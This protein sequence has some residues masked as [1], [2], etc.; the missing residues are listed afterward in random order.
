VSRT[1][2]DGI[3]VALFAALAAAP[4]VP[5]R[6]LPMVDLPQHELV[7]DALRRHLSGT[8]GTPTQL[9]AFTYNAGFEFGVLPLAPFLGVVT[10]GHVLLA[11]ACAGLVI[12]IARLRAL[13][14]LDRSPALVASLFT[15][16]YAASWG[17]ANF[18]LGVPLVFFALGDALVLHARPS[19]RA[20]ARALVTALA[21]AITHV[22]AAMAACLGLALVAL[23]DL[24][25]DRRRA[26]LV[27]WVRAGTPLAVAGAYDV[28]AFLWARA[29]PHAPWEN[30]WAEG[31][32]A[33][34]LVRLRD[35]AWNALGTSGDAFESFVV[36]GVLVTFA[37]ALLRRADDRGHAPAPAPDLRALPLG[38][39]AA[40]LFVP[41]VFVATFYVGERFASLA[42]LALVATA[43]IPARGTAAKAACAFA[44]V[45]A[46]LRLETTIRASDRAA[47]DGLAVLAAIPPSASLLPVNRDVS[48]TGF[49][50]APLRHLFARHALRSGAPVG[51]SF[52]RFESPP[53]RRTLP[54]AL[55]DPPPGF[56]GDGRGLAHDA[57]FAHAW[58]ALFVVDREG[59]DFASDA[60]RE[61]VAPGCGAHLELIAARGRFA[62]YRWVMRRTVD[63][64]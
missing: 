7:A 34:V 19:G 27:A 63:T 40:Y 37:F 35:L 24:V 60:Y 28:G 26:N 48:L 10:A 42:L 38:F 53:V 20:F 45:V 23:P 36:W 21:L 22:L 59:S 6:W 15:L 56:E 29:H 11:L 31:R 55:P 4:L 3:W 39:A 5:S 9:N 49:Q 64:R 17:F 41:T 25:R 50:R 47:R 58:Q 52:L 2:D 61:A 18:T 16:H 33:G 43:R 8:S 30:A 14:G 44:A 46:A 62:A 54:P 32:H 13:Q 51:Y 1:R 12:A 57:P